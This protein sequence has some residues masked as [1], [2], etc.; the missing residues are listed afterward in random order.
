M[1]FSF[2]GCRRFVKASKGWGSRLL[3]TGRIGWF[4]LDLDDRGNG[5]LRWLDR[6]SLRLRLR[7]DRDL[8]DVRCLRV[9]LLRGR[10]EL[11]WWSCVDSG[12]VEATDATTGVI[13]GG[14]VVIGGVVVEVGRVGVGVG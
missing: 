7:R 14:V 9:D 4:W 12:L 8:L 3:G 2:H 10:L 13:G 6:E 5:D 11:E 1:R